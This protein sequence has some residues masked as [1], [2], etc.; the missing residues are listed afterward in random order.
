MQHDSTHRTWP[1]R[2]PLRL[3][4]LVL[5]GLATLAATGCGDDAS[6]LDPDR[7]VQGGWVRYSP[8]VDDVLGDMAPTPPDTLF[9]ATDGTGR[10]SRT[11]PGTISSTPP[12]VSEDVRYG[13]QG[14]GVY[15]SPAC[16]TCRN[17]AAT[18]ALPQAFYRMRR[19]EADRLV[20]VPVA[21]DPSA[22]REYYL[23]PTAP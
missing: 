14:I 9:L 3:V 1:R 2:I 18:Y 8:P 4:I 20:L 10:W 21:G 13:R 7:G 15:L 12:R 22:G 16:P 17:A 19:P 11:V 5:V 23:R 6:F